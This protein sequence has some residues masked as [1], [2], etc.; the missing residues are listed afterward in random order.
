MKSLC[1]RW[2]RKDDDHR[3]KKSDREILNFKC[4]KVMR[5]RIL[6]GVCAFTPTLARS[7]LGLADPASPWPLTDTC[8]WKGGW[9]VGWMDRLIDGWMEGSMDEW[10][11]GWV[12]GWIDRQKDK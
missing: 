2:E 3:D 11:D 7:H 1:W 9:M 12:E 4:L 8:R 10:M 5:Q 6:K